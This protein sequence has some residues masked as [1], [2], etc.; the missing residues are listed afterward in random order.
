MNTNTKSCA[1]LTLALLLLSL[2]LS[3]PVISTPTEQFRAS[4]S[5][6]SG[7]E[8]A[9]TKIHPSLREL[10]IAGGSQDV[11]IIIATVDP[12]EIFG[13]LKHYR[14]LDPIGKRQAMSG[15]LVALVLDVPA[16][17][18]IK[19]AGLSSVAYIM[20]YELPEVTPPPD[21]DVP[22]GTRPEKIEPLTWF[23]IETHG[24]KAAWDK[25]YTGAGINVA[26]IDTGV[27]FGNPDLQGRQARQSFGPYAGW[28]IAF[29]ARSMIIY[30]LSSGLAF[31]AAD[32]WYSDTS[33][34]NTTG[35]IVTGTSLSGT[36][37]IGLHPDDTLKDLWYGNYVAVLI[38]DETVAGIYD[39]VYVDL[40]ND[41]NFTDEK[42]NRKGD[43]IAWRD[44]TGDDLADV[45]GGMVYFIADGVNGVPYSDTISSV[46]GMPNIIPAA[47]SLVAF[48]INDVTE[49]GGDHGTLV[50]S[51][52]AAQGV[53][54]GGIVRGMAK[55]A[56]IISIGNFY[57]A[58]LLYDS[59]YFATEGYD[60]IPGTGDEA[61][62][63]SMSFGFSSTINDGWD[64]QS[65]FIDYL[66]T[67]YNPSVTFFA[68]TG[69]G[70][71][72]YGTVTSPGASTGIISV[73]AATEY[74]AFES[75][76]DTD[77]ILW[78]DVQPWSNRGPNAV[79]QPDPDVVAVG[80]WGSGNLPLN[81]VGDGANAWT[82]WGGTSMAAPI[83][84][85]VTALMYQAYI[86]AHSVLPTSSIAREIMMSSATNLNY[87]PLVQGAGMVNGDRATDMASKSGGIIVSPPFWAAGR[88][89]GREFPAFTKTLLPGDVATTTFTLTNTWPSTSP[90]N[91]NNVN[92]KLSDSVLEKVGEYT[93]SFTAELAKESSF[94]TGRPD[95]L[96]DIT[97]IIPSGTNLMKAFAYFPFDKMDA[98]GDYTNTGNNGYRLLVYDWKDLDEDGKYWTDSN[99][100][101]VV[102]TGE[103]EPYEINRYTYGYPSGTAL[104]ARVHDPLTRYHDGI[105]LGIQHRYRT[106]LT[107]TVPIII[108]IEFYKKADWK[109]LKVTPETARVPNGGSVNIAAVLNL[110]KKTPL[111]LYEGTINLN[112]GTY[113]SVIPVVVNV[114]SKTSTFQFGGTSAANTLYDNGRVF[115]GFDWRWRYES[116]DWR[117]Y[118]VDVPKQGIASGTKLLLDVGW[119]TLPTDIDAFIFGP[120]R[121]IFSE[122][123]PNRYGPYTL[124]FKGGSVNTNMENGIFK[125]QTSTGGAR[126]V[127]AADAV[128]GLNLLAIHNVLYNDA[129]GE[130]F[131]AKLGT[132]TVSPYPISIT[133]GTST[134]TQ[135]VSVVSTLN[136]DGLAAMAFGV[137]QPEH[138]TGQTVY[139]DNPDDPMTASW[140]KEYMLT[141]AGVLDVYVYVGVNDLDL[142]ILYD[143][144]NDGV[145]EPNEIIASSINPAGI[146]DF[147]KILSPPDGRY[148]IFVHGWAVSPSP[149]T[150]DIDITI[151]QGTMLTVSNL[152]VGSVTAGT[153]V[154]F[155]LNYDLDE[156]AAGT[157]QGILFVGPVNAPTAVAIPVEIVYNP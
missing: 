70:G 22:I 43:E 46:Y 6:I 68:S 39:T 131:S 114:A 126:E 24:A 8:R 86:N 16:Y 83:A 13:V 101:G 45:S 121:D 21:E 96:W 141:N 31:P 64:F 108:K 48:M 26:V 110:P 1:L 79:G 29:D 106:S 44:L 93:I 142:Y 20:N 47:G 49:S 12:N 61:H 60:G 72:G 34:T 14:N 148:W 134:G 92:V 136:L 58:G 7:S 138:L 80:A 90:A 88:F 53:I 144:D 111:G 74:W 151:I 35:Y 30:L 125:F 99:D 139:Q 143:E 156:I 95:Y 15:K 52:V 40:D 2:V 157:W 115:G 100:N 129:F 97:G 78:G 4:T 150:F 102:N 127:I 152:P 119:T 76:N 147:V 55:D 59:L 118:Y 23:A 3:S 56:K 54:G 132:F 63:V 146:D 81:E 105:L 77:Q 117:F 62:E 149:S 25:G 36:Y 137:S 32:V 135:L 107:P 67:F 91:P 9:L 71:H 113:E 124:D 120:E 37:H 87:D 94:S 112:Y 145:P 133:T 82:V 122:I 57:Q 65:R 155:N 75:I 41:K 153:T 18:L 33:S 66:T 109:W 42:L 27:D 116:G 38:V 19:L 130:Y 89:E 103:M 123:W 28:P 17:S 84:A 10:A 69:N 11:K 50:A 98:N 51:S 140:T 154:T 104:E 5:I 85:G 128:S 73:G